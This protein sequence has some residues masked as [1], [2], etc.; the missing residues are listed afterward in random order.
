MW[1][2]RD[3]GQYLKN[4]RDL[5]A[6]RDRAFPEANQRGMHCTPEQRVH[7]MHTY[8]EDFKQNHAT[9]QQLKKGSVAVKSCAEARLNRLAGSRLV[10]FGIWEVGLPSLHSDNLDLTLATEQR[11]RQIEQDAVRVLH[12][13]D[14][15]ASAVHGYRQ[16]AKYSEATR[17]AGSHKQTGLTAAELAEKKEMLKARQALRAGARLARL[18]NSYDLTYENAT[19]EEYDMLWAYWR[20]ELEDAYQERRS[21]RGNQQLRC[22]LRVRPASHLI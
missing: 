11:R 10:I 7:I 15:I 22:E 1:E 21:A 19:A 5:V 2:A 8:I 17:K 3:A 4:W 12:F 16:T 13:L 9:P 20:G 14:D 18:W 6:F